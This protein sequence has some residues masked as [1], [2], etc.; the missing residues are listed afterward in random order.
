[1][2]TA[3]QVHRRTGDE[4]YEPQYRQHHEESAADIARAALRRRRPTHQHDGKSDE[5]HRGHDRE[6]SDHGSDQGVDEGSDRSGRAEPDTGTHHQGEG[7]Q[8][9]GDSV[10][11]MRMACRAPAIGALPGYP[12]RC[13]FG[14]VAG[15]TG[16]GE[17]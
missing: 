10:A 12:T 16:V 5:R 15:R 11:P 6:R 8:A 9:Q 3:G 1:M 13:R 7:Q 4:M 17:V 2:R 14:I